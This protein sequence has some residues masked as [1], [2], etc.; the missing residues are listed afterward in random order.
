MKPAKLFKSGNSQRSN[1]KG[2]QLEGHE[3]EITRKS[4]IIEL[5]PNKES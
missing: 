2:I 5:R 3:V 1:S 4:D